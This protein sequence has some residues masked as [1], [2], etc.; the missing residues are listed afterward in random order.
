MHNKTIMVCLLG[1]GLL[2]PYMPAEAQTQWLRKSPI[3]WNKKPNPKVPAVY[4]TKISLIGHRATTVSGRLPFFVPKMSADKALSFS[5]ALMHKIQ[6]QKP[7]FRQPKLLPFE[8]YVRHFIFTVSERGAK[9]AFKGTG[10]VIA[11]RRDGQTVLWGLS[12]AH[13]V[14]YMGKDV[15]VT[16]YAGGEKYTYPAEVVLTGRKYGLNAALIKLPPEAAE[17]ARPVIGAP[18]AP[19][20]GEPLFTFGFSAGTYKKT[21]RHV[22][23]AGGERIVAN[24]P[25][26]NQP[27]PGFCGSVVLN[28]Q[29]QAIGIEVGG[30]SPK[31]E[32]QQWY[33]L[34]RELRGLPQ[35]DLASIS[36]IVPLSRAYDLLEAYHHPGQAAR[37]MWFD[38]MRIGMLAPDEFVESVGVHYADGHHKLLVRNPFMELA[39]LDKFFPLSGAVQAEITVNK[40][41]TKTYTYVIRLDTKQ[42][43]KK[44]AW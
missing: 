2:V 3:L 6:M 23:F 43:E 14:R 7:M 11:E 24:F 35:A 31:K 40:H 36:E 32:G 22:L 42:I 25:S 12:G 4:R 28:G 44:E 27:K 18:Q 20:A 21:I 29:G 1:L 17:V 16:F 26:H 34:R 13:V 8:N 19:Q 41:R 5:R 9:D 37:T 15:D 10:F 33:Q 38:G 30:Y 39:A